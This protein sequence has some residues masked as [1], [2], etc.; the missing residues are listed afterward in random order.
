MLYWSVSWN[1]N[2]C[3]ERSLPGAL[4]FCARRVSLA[5]SAS[6]RSEL[7]D[8]G[9]RRCRLYV[10]YTFLPLT[11][12]RDY[13]QIRPSVCL[14]YV[15]QMISTQ[16]VPASGYSQWRRQV[17]KCENTSHSS[18]IR[19][20]YGISIP[21]QLLIFFLTSI[22]TPHSGVWHSWREWLGLSL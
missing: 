19:Q 22:V 16:S 4:T 18:P 10:Y 15:M 5:F 9:L 7:C 11:S 12:W 6:V 21:K 8:T 2:C 1:T 20:C 14:V 3:T 17:R 13:F